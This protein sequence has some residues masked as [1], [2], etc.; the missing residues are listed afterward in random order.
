MNRVCVIVWLAAPPIVSPQLGSS[1][2][3]YQ[4]SPR[5]GTQNAPGGFNWA[6][7]RF[8]Y[9]TTGQYEQTVP[10]SPTHVGSE[11]RP[12]SQGTVGSNTGTEWYDERPLSRGSVGTAPS[13]NATGTDTSAQARAPAAVSEPEWRPDLQ[14]YIQYRGDAWYIS[15]GDEW[16]LWGSSS[17]SSA[18]TQAAPS[19]YGG[20]SGSSGSRGYGR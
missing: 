10:R 20:Y 12:S 4:A 18:S 17:T 11:G 2:M 3:A 13:N 9:G 7:V 15:R 14:A 8:P 1:H 5:R 16:V 19:S 6:P